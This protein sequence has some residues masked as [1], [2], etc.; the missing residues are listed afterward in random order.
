MLRN[1]A[2]CSPLLRFRAWAI[3][4]GKMPGHNLYFTH[5]NDTAY[6]ENHSSVQCFPCMFNVVLAR[7]DCFQDMYYRNQADFASFND[8]NL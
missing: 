5:S 6:N 2:E 8:K 7:V 4:C 1:N 3:N